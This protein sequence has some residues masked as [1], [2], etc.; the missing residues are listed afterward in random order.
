MIALPSSIVGWL[1]T[2]T[3]T[4]WPASEIKGI[5]WVYWSL[6]FEIAFYLL[7]SIYVAIPRLL[8]PILIGWS[9]FALTLPDAPIF[10]LSGWSLFALGAAI[11]EFQR[12]KTPAAIGL[13]GLCLADM[14]LNR[15]LEPSFVGAITAL[16]V[17]AS[18]T[19]ALRWV[20]NEPLLCRVG[21]FSYSLYLSH[22][23]IAAWIFLRNVDPY[24]RTNSADNFLWHL[25][26]DTSALIAALLGAY[27]FY[28]I[29]EKPSSSMARREADA[30]MES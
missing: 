23:P 10:F 9:F 29:V 30:Q 1:H 15:P 26:M 3:L 6:T 8:W 5:N 21:I 2:L 24:P 12:N 13:A 16:G 27:G 20:N 11:S 22:V 17:V 7:A 18:T 4:T 19:P 28:R 25:C 14:F